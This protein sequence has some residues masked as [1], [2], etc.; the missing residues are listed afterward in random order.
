MSKNVVI[1]IGTRE[2]GITFYKDE[3]VVETHNIPLEDTATRYCNVQRID[4]K[5]FRELLISFLPVKGIEVQY[6]DI[7]SL[8][9]NMVESYWYGKNLGY[10]EGICPALGITPVLVIIN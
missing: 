3:R 1:K 2:D 5:Q 8:K 6:K 4:I 7:N 9:L 10:I